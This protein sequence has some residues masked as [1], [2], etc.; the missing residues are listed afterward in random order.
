[1]RPKSAPAGMLAKIIAMLLTVGALVLGFMFSVIALALVAVL[2]SIV[3][4][5]FWW[6]TRALRKA[7]RQQMASARAEQSTVIEGEATVVR[8]SAGSGQS[9]LFVV[10]GK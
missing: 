9:Q 4:G 7:I 10:T 1:M 8:E 3:F 6:R 5:Y 2:G